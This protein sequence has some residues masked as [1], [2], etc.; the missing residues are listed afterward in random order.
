MKPCC[1]D[2]KNLEPVTDAADRIVLRCLVCGCQHYRFKVDP[3]VIGIKLR[4][5]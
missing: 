3:G 4:K 5:S 1:Q 2:P